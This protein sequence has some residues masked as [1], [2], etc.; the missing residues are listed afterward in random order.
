VTS[1]KHEGWRRHFFY[2]RQS[3]R[4]TWKF[5]AGTLLVAILIAMMTRGFWTVRIGESLVC[6]DKPVPSDILLLENFDPNYLVFERAA[7]LE[8]AGFASRALVPV[9]A[10]SDPTIANAI[11]K[12]IAELMARQARLGALE[13]IPILETEPISLTAALQI[14]DH[15]AR[16]NV[17][18][19]IVVAP[20]FRSRRSSL[21]YRTVLHDVRMQVSCTP[22]FGRTNPE[23]WMDTWHGIQDVAQEFVKLQYY[24]FYVIPF[25][26]RSAGSRVVTEAAAVIGW[27]FAQVGKA[28]SLA[29]SGE[30]IPC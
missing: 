17:R 5:R 25:L 28:S 29:L 11:S 26:S 16:E 24:R 13:I 27:I 9:E 7:E 4:T 2:T 20:G 22:V 23:N 8:K 30:S 12:G 3:T 1:R 18:S 15:L 6:A 10:S 14:R 19:V 21:V